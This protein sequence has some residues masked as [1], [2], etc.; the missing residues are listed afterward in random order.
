MEDLSS[1]T[2]KKIRYFRE[3]VNESQL[4]I[5][6]AMN[7]SPGTLSRI[8]NG[9]TNPTKETLL[10]ISRYL[11]LNRLE[12]AYLL[13]DTDKPSSIEE[14]N[15]VRDRLKEYFGKKDVVAYLTDDRYRLV[16]ASKGIQQLMDVSPEHLKKLLGESLIK[17]LMDDSLGIKKFVADDEYKTILKNLI[18]RYYVEVGFMICDE[19]N[20]ETI[21]FILHNS[22]A[23]KYWEESHKDYLENKSI[24][25][26]ESR[27]VTFKFGF[28]TVPMYFTVEPLTWN[29]RFQMVEYMPT[30]LIIR[31][32]QKL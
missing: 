31:L 9:Q 13:G 25:T 32:L 26:L 11:K 5:E 28:L 23:K 30:N 22:E 10:K 12:T 27:K 4:N 1:K 17:I 15:E 20:L 16:A 24:Y 19:K 8:E 3:R 7:A 14:I 29:E 18:Y 2:G 21:E 6:L